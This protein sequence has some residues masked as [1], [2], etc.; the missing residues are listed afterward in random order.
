[1][2]RCCVPTEEKIVN[3]LN[4]FP[5]RNDSITR[6]NETIVNMSGGIQR[7]TSLAVGISKEKEQAHSTVFVV[8]FLNKKDK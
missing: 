8:T 3:L 7:S 2:R 1:M 6:M 4:V 5:Q